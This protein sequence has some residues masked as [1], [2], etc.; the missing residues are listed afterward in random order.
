MVLRHIRPPPAMT[1]V[2]SHEEHDEDDEESSPIDLS[3][4]H[5]VPPSEVPRNMSN[6]PQISHPRVPPTARMLHGINSRLCRTLGA[7]SDVRW[8]EGP[9]GLL[10]GNDDESSFGEEE[11]IPSSEDR[12]QN[13][14]PLSRIQARY[15]QRHDEPLLADESPDD[16]SHVSPKSDSTTPDQVQSKRARLD[17][18]ISHIKQSKPLDSSGRN[19]DDNS[20][21]EHRVSYGESGPQGL[22]T[23]PREPP[24]FNILGLDRFRIHASEEDE[25][26]CNLACSK[27]RPNTATE[28]NLIEAWK[29]KGPLK[30]MPPM[31]PSEAA[32]VYGVDPET[33]QK[34]MIQL[35]LTSAA[36]MGDSGGLMKVMQGCPP[37]VFFGYYSQILQNFQAQEILRQYAMQSTN[38]TSTIIQD[39]TVSKIRF[40]FRK[41]R[42]APRREII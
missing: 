29:N 37:W 27:Q 16:H 35:Q 12:R 11:D 6:K 14:I 8:R 34:H 33:Y 10:S 32:K 9:Q 42:K 2:V 5:N 41:K 3:N 31:S 22:Q 38:P 24:P 30:G 19:S 21:G 13:F 36:M 17:C 25:E 4:K 26:P 40:Y 18:L 23:S 1:T 20:S 28:A 7:Q 39:E 15:H